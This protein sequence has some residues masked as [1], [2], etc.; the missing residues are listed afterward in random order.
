MHNTSQVLPNVPAFCG[1]RSGT[2]RLLAVCMPFSELVRPERE[3]VRGEK[4]GEIRGGL[5]VA[6]RICCGRRCPAVGKRPADP[7]GS[8]GCSSGEL[9]TRRPRSDGGITRRKTLYYGK[10]ICKVD[11]QAEET[12]ETQDRHFW[13]GPFI[14]NKTLT[15]HRVG[16][17][18]LIQKASEVLKSSGVPVDGL[19]TEVSQG[20]RRIGFDVVTLS[21]L[22]GVLSRIRSEPPPRKCECRVGLYVVDL[23]SFEHLALRS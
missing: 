11:S 13:Q 14:N 4:D 15:V 18:T 2:S 23:T 5:C 17:T 22:Q 7:G 8:L 9:G 3:G 12:Q 21:G 16:K 19:Y 20:G 6:P 10:E 1:R